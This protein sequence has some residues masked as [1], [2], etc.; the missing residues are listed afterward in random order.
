MS[1]M[2]VLIVDDQKA[3]RSLVRSSLRQIGIQNVVE[4]SDGAEA[5]IEFIHN[6]P[7]LI[8]SDWNMPNL[9]GMGLL[10]AVRKQPGME[11]TPFIMLTSRNEVD[12]VK[13][14]I[15]IGVNNY[16]MKPFNLQA[17]KRKIEIVM[18]PWE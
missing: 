10:R 13:E 9:D 12:K 8:I 1:N 4:C 16:L 2:R 5:L 3:L 14:A 11:G 6:A 17:L 18:G 15:A 7:N